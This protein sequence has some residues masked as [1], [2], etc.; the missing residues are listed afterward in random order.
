MTTLASFAAAMTALEVLYFISAPFPFL[1]GNFTQI[2]PPVPLD[3]C[4]FF[5]VFFLFSFTAKK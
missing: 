1:Y 4:P 5:H 3:P 2:C